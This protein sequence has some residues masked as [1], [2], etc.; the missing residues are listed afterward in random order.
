MEK[1]DTKAFDDALTEIG[2]IRHFFE[3]TVTEMIDTLDTLDSNWYGEAGHKYNVF[4]K[5]FKT[6]MSLDTSQ[7]K[8]IEDSLIAIRQAYLDTDMAIAD[9]LKGEEV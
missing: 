6:K 1:L 5:A 3:N 7:I 4:L 9:S 2:N 8:S